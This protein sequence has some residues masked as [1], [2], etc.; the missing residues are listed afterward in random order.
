MTFCRLNSGRIDEDVIWLN[1]DKKKLQARA[2]KFRAMAAEEK[3]NG[4]ESDARCHALL[5]QLETPF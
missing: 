4:W 1:H 2:D 3:S 5:K